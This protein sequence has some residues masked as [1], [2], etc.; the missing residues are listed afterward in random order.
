MGELANV[1]VV[2]GAGPGMGLAI[3]RRFAAGGVRPVL[4]A[5]DPGRLAAPDLDA[6]GAVRLAADVTD[7]SSL[8]AAFAQVRRSVGDPAV[9]VFNP[10]LGVAGTPTEVAPEVV[11]AGLAVGAI[12]AVTATQEVVPAMRSAGRGSLLFTG[13][14]VAIKPWVGG[15]SLSMQKA[16][17]RSY[18]LALAEEVEPDGIHAATV[19][20]QGLVGSN[21]GFAPEALAEHF[22]TLHTQS[23][24]SWQA[25]LL[26][27]G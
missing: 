14:A 21:P 19:T 18:V 27:T 5:R 26:A 25:E 12:A 11:S 16:A 7:T 8:Q 15:V 13:S 17:L 6:L 4:V 3:A 23:R 1:A 9:M 24:D 2:V 10:S 20:I 22:W